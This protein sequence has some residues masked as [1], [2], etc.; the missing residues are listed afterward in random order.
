M[1]KMIY[2]FLVTAFFITCKPQSENPYQIIV[3]AQLT[4]EEG[5]S[6]KERAGGELLMI[7]SSEFTNIDPKGL[8]PNIAQV[9]FNDVQVPFEQVG[10]RTLKMKVPIMLLSLYVRINI[11]IRYLRY[12]IIIPEFIIYRPT[13]TGEVLAGNDG[14]FQM[15]AEMTI[16]ATGNLYVIDQRTD[17]DVIFKITPE[18]VTSL[19]A[20][21]KNEFGRLVGIGIDPAASRMYVADATAQ[22]VKWFSFPTPT[23]VSVLAGSGT[24]G[25]TDGTGTAA[26]FT[27]GIERVDDFGTNEKGQGLTVD[28]AGNIYVGEKFGTDALLSQIRKITPAGEVT[29]VPGSRISMVM[30]PDDWHSPSGLTILQPTGEVVYIGGASSLYQGI[31]RVTTAGTMVRI[32]GQNSHEDLVDG[33]GV[34]AEFAY[35]KALSYFN[36]YYHVADGTN[37]AYRRVTTTGQ[38]ITIAG[39][40][41]F[42][43]PSYCICGITGPVSASYIFPSIF[44]SNPDK[45]EIAASAII[46]DQVGGIAVRNNRLVYLS[47]YGRDFKCIWK[48]RIE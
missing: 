25:N 27:L 37:G 36:G 5:I 4:D 23:T 47:D 7:T 14:T 28:G 9:Y 42:A 22:Q 18:G 38:V 26:S 41:H 8:S 16:D 30:G 40:G 21:G 10:P 35:P 12:N 24:A 2:C 48:I 33:T 6:V 19:F 44:D 29:T 20:G 11:N 13:V 31:A 3:H 15:P 43:T 34:N 45:H 1:N 39:V 17:H 46:M 32:A